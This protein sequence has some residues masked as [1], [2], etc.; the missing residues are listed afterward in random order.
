M[1]VGPEKESTGKTIIVTVLQKNQF[2]LD[3]LDG[4]VKELR[5]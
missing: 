1:N 4:K 3:N 5:Y 2:S